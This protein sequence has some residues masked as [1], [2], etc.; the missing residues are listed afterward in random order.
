MVKIAIAKVIN[1]ITKLAEAILKAVGNKFN[2]IT[3]IIAPVTCAG[4][5]NLILFT[6]TTFTIIDIII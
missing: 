5:Y 2:P 1:A 6:P 3:T 4:K